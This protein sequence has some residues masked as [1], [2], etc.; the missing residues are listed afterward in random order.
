VFTGEPVT[1]VSDDPLQ[2]IRFLC[3]YLFM[4]VA[5]S[6]RSIPRI[7]A[8]FNL[9]TPLVIGW[10]PHFTSVINWVLRFGL[11]L[12]KQVKPIDQDWLAIIDHS[13]SI[14]TKK[15]LVVLRISLDALA[16]RGSAVKLEDC[17]CIGLKISEEVN[18]YTIAD[19]LDDIFAKS[20][21]PKAIIKDCDATLNKGCRLTAASEHDD[22]YCIDDIGHYVASALKADYAN[23]DTFKDFV[24]IAAKGAK[25]LY[26]TNLACYV[27][28]K[29][30][31]KGRF[32]SISHLGKWAKKILPIL[33]MDEDAEPD[34][35]EERLQKVFAGLLESEPC[36]ESFC[37]T[38]DLTNQVMAL[39]KNKGLDESSHKECFELSEF[40]PDGSHIKQRLQQW[41]NKQLVIC[42]ALTERASL[43]SSDIIE[44]LFGQFKYIL[45][46]GACADMNRMILVIPAMCGCQTDSS[47][48]YALS[49][50]NQKDLN[51]WVQSEIGLTVHQ[52]KLEFNRNSDIQKSVKIVPIE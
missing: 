45:S 24:S 32:Q 47:T 42:K 18:G 16:D 29:L 6:F 46:R 12:L 43:V 40:L 5:V 21:N 48:D 51:N 15:V 50:V 26:Q 23:K 7:L 36:I 49:Q 4:N 10:T 27:P 44:S 9:K 37:D 17:E 34:S 11:G 13:I 22:V 20:G 28:P 31:T 39:L 41:L 33:R 25:F 19:D 30:R 35:D 1:N 2:P 8:A 52:K 14:G 38:C 3:I